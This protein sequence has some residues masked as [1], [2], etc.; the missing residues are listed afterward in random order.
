MQISIM[1]FSNLEIKNI[2]DLTRKSSNY[3]KNNIV[4]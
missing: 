3:I 1:H 2:M 4:T